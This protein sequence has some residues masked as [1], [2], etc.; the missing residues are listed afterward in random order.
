MTWMTPLIWVSSWLGSLIAHS[1]RVWLITLITCSPSCLMYQLCHVR[2]L[3]PNIGN[4][5]L[6]TRS[7][8]A[9]G[10]DII[11][12]LLQ[13]LPLRVGSWNGMRAWVGGWDKVWKWNGIPSKY[14]FQD[15]Q[16]APSEV[17][18]M[19]EVCKERLSMQ[20]ARQNSELT[21]VESRSALTWLKT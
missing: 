16:M 7:L 3:T 15:S 17:Q 9:K 1:I 4:G 10:Y 11:W 6:K 2:L 5:R 8:H 19:Y 13:E 18:Y 20:T 14:W 12:W 21:C